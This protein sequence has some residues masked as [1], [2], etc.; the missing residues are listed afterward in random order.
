MNNSSHYCNIHFITNFID[1][2]MKFINSHL[3]ILPKFILI[4]IIIFI[5]ILI[6]IH[7]KI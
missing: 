7:L 6:F 5:L 1:C 4:F 2:F 3:S